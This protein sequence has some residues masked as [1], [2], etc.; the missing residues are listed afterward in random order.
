V[1]HVEVV[2]HR[3]DRRDRPRLVELLQVHVADAEVPDQALLPQ[4][5][6]HLEPRPERLPVVRH[7]TADP[8][9]DQVQPVQAQLRQVP[10]HQRAEPVRARLVRRHAVGAAQRS[11]LGRDHQVVGVRGERPADQVVGGD[12]AADVE[13]GRV[14]VV[15]AQ[16]DRPAQHRDAGLGVARRSRQGAGGQAHRAEAEPPYR[17]VAAQGEGAAKTVRRVVRHER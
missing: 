6:E 4:R 14:E 17:Q 5:R 7:Q 13:V 11:D 3:R 12:L 8:Q 9:V 10:L 15:H 16:L 2:L 1:L